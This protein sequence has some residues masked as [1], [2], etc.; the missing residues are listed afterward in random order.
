MKQ[1]RVLETGRS[2]HSAMSPR[3]R[4][5]F[6]PDRILCSS[7]ILGDFWR[8]KT[9]DK[10]PCP[11]CHLPKQVTLRW[12]W[13][14]GWGILTAQLTAA[15]TAESVSCLL[16]DKEDAG[17]NFLRNLR[18]MENQGLCQHPRGTRGHPLKW[19]PP[20]CSAEGLQGK[21]NHVWFPPVITVVVSW[22]YTCAHHLCERQG[23]A[24]VYRLRPGS[25]Q[26]SRSTSESLLLSSNLK[27]PLGRPILTLSH[28]QAAVH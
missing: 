9:Q 16:S 13:E 11:I 5:L 8:N 22:G 4:R 10:F 26:Q 3:Q 27:Y 1:T 7:Q 12:W 21:R 23:L 18:S 14:W 24:G 17:D 25:R 20:T 28:G 2:L 6:C 19:E 15:L